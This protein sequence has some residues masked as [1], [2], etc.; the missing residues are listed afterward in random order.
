MRPNPV[1]LFLE[2]VWCRDKASGKIIEYK[3]VDCGTSLLSGDYFVLQDDKGRKE[4][5][6]AQVL[7]EM[8]VD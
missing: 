5:V 8:R 2:T 1:D 6:T 7:S 4:Q 3:V